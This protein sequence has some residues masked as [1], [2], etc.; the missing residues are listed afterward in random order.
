MAR[1]PIPSVEADFSSVL[2]LLRERRIVSSNPPAELQ[3]LA[4]QIHGHTYSL[5]L[6]RF[7]LSGLSTHGKAFIEEIASDALQV[8]PQILMGYSKTAK[9]LI[10]GIIENAL[11]HVYFYDH[12]IEFERMNREKK[13]FLTIE[14]LCEYVKLHPIFW[15]IEPQSTQ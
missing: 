1:Q 12:P 15:R 9:L 3:R 13:W 14:Q 10:R 7:R 2:G 6:W 11:R 8:L 4:R 5:I